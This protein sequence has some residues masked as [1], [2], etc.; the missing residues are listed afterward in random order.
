MIDI[1]S[2]YRLYESYNIFTLYIYTIRV[3]LNDSMF[4]LLFIE[5]Y[6]LLTI[7][8]YRLDDE[9][10]LISLTTNVW[11]CWYHNFEDKWKEERSFCQFFILTNPFYSYTIQ[12][13]LFSGCWYWIFRIVKFK[14][15]FSL[16]KIQNFFFLK[17][18]WTIF[19]KEKWTKN[20][21]NQLRNENCL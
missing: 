1:N 4:G 14:M 8:S 5:T 18:W 20:Y 16:L 11:V 9:F 15:A 13:I 12:S 3:K 19:L 10:N 17:C 6:V 7:I 21:S 2:V